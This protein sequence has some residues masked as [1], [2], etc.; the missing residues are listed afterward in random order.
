MRKLFFLA[1]LVAMLP[2][3]AL[4]A[5]LSLPVKSFAAPALNWTGFYVGGNAGA[6]W[7]RDAISN[8]LAAPGFIPADIA[9]V[10]SAASPTISSGGAIGGGQAGYNQQWGSWLVGVEAD[11]DYLGLKGSN[12]G[13]FPFPSTLPGG[14]VG[15][16][17]AFFSTAI[18]ASTTWLFT[19]RPRIGWAAGNWLL[20]ATGG[21]A[22]GR[23][24]VTE[25]VNLLAPF[26]E[27]SGF[28]TTRAGWTA[29]AGVE[30]AINRNWSVKGE[31]L[32]VDLGS[33]ATAAT[34]SPPF[35][36]LT[37]TGSVRL[38]TEIARGGINYRF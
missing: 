30:Y 3:Y 25:T 19:A 1:S 16:P 17:T 20:Y 6:A 8:T 23:E 7:G 26:V 36:G 10:S 15:P 24:S 38:T 2:G 29:G 9:A 4:A 27:T 11:F 13:T 22:V 37:L 12:G 32:H 33:V 14:A 5:D 18:S 21:L 28:A 35:P 31:Y 34:T